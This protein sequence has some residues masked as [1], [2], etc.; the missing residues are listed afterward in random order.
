MK[1]RITVRLNETQMKHIQSLI[2]TRSVLSASDCIRQAL[3]FWLRSQS[4]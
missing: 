3:D 4:S 2:N 1:A